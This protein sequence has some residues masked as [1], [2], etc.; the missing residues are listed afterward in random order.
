MFKEII[1]K[2]AYYIYIYALQFYLYHALQQM[3]PTVGTINFFKFFF[4]KSQ[5][6]QMIL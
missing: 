5:L 3:A 2:S 6:F 1:W 4:M